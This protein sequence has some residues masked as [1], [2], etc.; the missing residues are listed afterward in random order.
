[1]TQSSAASKPP[2]VVPAGPTEVV[3]VMTAQPVDCV[4]QNRREVG[5][6]VI[7]VIEE[8]LVHQLSASHLPVLAEV[9]SLG[10]HVSWQ[11]GYLGLLHL[12]Q[13]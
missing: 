10:C 5:P 6:G 13:K 12:S 2:E 3:G 7:D 11:G 1:M 4:P 9:L 8:S